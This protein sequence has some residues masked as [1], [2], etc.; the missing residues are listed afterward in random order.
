[1]SST[2]LGFPS[3]VFRERQKPDVGRLPLFSDL[4]YSLFGDMMCPL[5]E[6]TNEI[7]TRVPSCHGGMITG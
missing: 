3:A 4:G 6:K 7:K 2:V 1:M 5:T